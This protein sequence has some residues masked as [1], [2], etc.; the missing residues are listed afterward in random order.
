M[1]ELGKLIE[2][3]VSK[4]AVH[5]AVAPVIAG[6]QLFPGK[7]VRLVNG[8]AFNWDTL[9]RNKEDSTGIV[10]PFLTSPVNLGERFWLVLNPGTVLNLHHEWNHPD[11]SDEDLAPKEDDWCTTQNCG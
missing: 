11:F 1:I 2:G 9:D 4:D 10:D 5:M 8:R 3:T 6:E 7:A